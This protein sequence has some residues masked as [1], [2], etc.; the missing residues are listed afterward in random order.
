VGCGMCRDSGLCLDWRGD[1]DT[2][3]ILT[4]LKIFNRPVKI[5]LYVATLDQ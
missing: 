1:I 5:S 4:K 3:L 2:L